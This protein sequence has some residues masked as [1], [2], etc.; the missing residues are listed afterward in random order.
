MV[1]YVYWGVGLLPL[2]LWLGDTVQI[3]GVL[4]VARQLA[5]VK[6]VET[7]QY[8]LKSH[9]MNSTTQPYLGK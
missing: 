4:V 1:M 5:L 8:T 7:F 3:V 2:G 6:H 9:E